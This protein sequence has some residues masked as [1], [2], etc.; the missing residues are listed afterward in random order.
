VIC[1]DNDAG[2][3]GNPGLTHARAAAR[4]VGADVVTPDFAGVPA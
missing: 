2:T 4:A 3:P 1:A